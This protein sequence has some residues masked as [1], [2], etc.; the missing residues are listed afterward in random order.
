[1]KRLVVLAILLG[2]LVVAVPSAEAANGG[3]TVDTS[4]VSFV[5]S[6]AACSNLPAGTT[7]YGSGTEKSITTTIDANGVTT[8]VNSTHANGTAYD[9]AGNTYVFNY[10]NSFRASNT[11]AN[12]AVFSG[13]MD[14]AFSLAGN[15]PASLHNGF[16]AGFTTDFT[17]WT[18]D[19]KHANGDPISFAS[20]PVVAHCDPL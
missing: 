1:V 13:S 17:S 7:I 14:D 3:T 8:L 4:P 5:M 19:V 2:V 18:W 9:L 11:V 16:N 20:G 10:A 6:S 15:G 12:P